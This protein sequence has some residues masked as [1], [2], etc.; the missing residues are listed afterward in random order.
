MTKSERGPAEASK[1]TDV[2]HMD[3]TYMQTPTWQV[4][5]LL[6][7]ATGE[8]QDQGQA[9]TTLLRRMEGKNNLEQ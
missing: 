5:I 8:P 7:Q 2:F 3:G 9:Q 1:H 6:L 4:D